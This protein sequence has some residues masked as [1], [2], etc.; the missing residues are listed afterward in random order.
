V[1][2]CRCELPSKE[3]ELRSSQA[4]SSVSEVERRG[5]V[6][7]DIDGFWRRPAPR[8][9]AANIYLQTFPKDSS[10]ASSI[11]KSSSR[12]KQ[13]NLTLIR[14][15]AKAPKRTILS[16]IT[17]Y[18]AIMPR[19]DILELVQAL[20]TSGARAAATFILND[21]QF[22]AIPQLAR[23]M[24][25]VPSGMNSGDSDVDLI[26]YRLSDASLFEEFQ[27]LPVPGGED[28]EFFSIGGRH[29]LA[30]ASLR[31]GKGP[32]NMVE[33]VSSAI[34][35]WQDGK[36]VEFQR[37]PTFAAKQWRYFAIEGRSFLA[38]A[39]GVT[40]P[41]ITARIPPESVIYEWDA[42][43]SSFVRFQTVPSGWG[44]NWLHFSLAGHDFLA[45][46]DQEM[47][48]VILRWENGKFEHFQALE[49]ALGRAFCFIETENESLLAFANIADDT[50]LYAW[51]GN[52]FQIRQRL[53]GPGGRE[54]ALVKHAEDSYLILVRFIT[55]SRQAPKTDLQ[56]AIYRLV[57]GFLEEALAFPTFGAT[58]CSIMTVK[59][60]TWLVVC[61]SLD[62]DQN[63]RVDTHIYRF[64]P[65]PATA[66]GDLPPKYTFQSSEFLE[67]FQVYTA[68][69]TSLGTQLA[70]SSSAKTSQY[71][72]LAATSSS[73][74][75]FPGCGGDPSYVS[76]RLTNRGFKEL[77]AISHFG[78]ALASLVQMYTVN[79]EDEAWRKHAQEL[80]DAAEK[81]KS[82]NSTELWR[83]RIRVEA[84][85]GREGAIAA[86]V[87]YACAITMKYLRLVISD[88]T[89]LTS[90]FLQ[91]EYLEARGSV[92]GATV[93]I[94]A[95]MIATFFLVGLDLAYQ[96]KVWLQDK[97]MDW[98]KTMVLV[99]GK[100]GRETAGVTVTSNAV[101][102]VIF[103]S[104][105]LM[106]PVERLYIAPHGP[107]IVVNNA[108]DM[109]LLRQYEKPM[110]MLWN[111]NFAMAQ[112]GPTMFG[113]YPRYTPEMRSRPIIAA[114]TTELS[115]MPAIHGPDDWMAMTTRMRIVLEDVRQLLSGC[116]TDYAAEQLRLH[117]NNPYAVVVPGLDHFNY[118][119]KP[120]VPIYPLNGG[121]NERSDDGKLLL[122]SS[123]FELEMEF[124]FPSQKCT[125]GDAEIAFREEGSG[126]QTIIWVHGLPLDS[127]SW[128]AQRLHF[129]KGYHNVYLDLRGYGES[130]KLPDEVQDV[131]QIYC[132]DI[133]TLMD[134]LFIQ[135]AHLVGFASAGHVALRFAAQNPARIQKL[136]TINGTPRFRRGEDWP[137]GFSE[138]AIESFTSAA[139]RD[140]IR[141]ITAAVLDPSVVFREL[142]SVD[143]QKVKAWFEKMSHNAGTKT[144]L[145]FFNHISRDDDRH[146]VPQILAPT[147]LITG[148]MSQEVPS[149]SAMYLRQNIKDARMVEIP[150]ADHFAFITRPVIV[151]ALIEGFLSN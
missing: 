146:L 134:H 62:K 36:F 99:I 116:V 13:L 117:G 102:Q 65:Q 3:S 33:N 145:G 17:H 86:M 91:E 98:T 57:D 18:A 76:F 59:D 143:A 60:E 4:V 82:A 103:Q 115:D 90:Q 34:W 84:F 58:D 151:N 139:A 42:S 95:V 118:P 8:R 66:R 150:D 124:D 19:P 75:L 71:P 89:K 15:E 142:S 120:R 130:S 51:D 6:G 74:L 147:L 107:N 69:D 104:S 136:V 149:Q 11:E 24:A 73:L 101:A 78:P 148:S 25:G 123:P 113:G 47:P 122:S 39:Q 138:E 9:S 20:P 41:G 55:G 80:L 32:Y 109:E 133:K 79:S 14:R 108:T 112:L 53:K 29:F 46:A 77:A 2:T 16:R 132:D 126:E 1:T 105:N 72:L 121:A 28:A 64:N 140:G 63:F 67:L 135:R 141:G 144:L 45:Y 23:D 106:L 81:A 87:D 56:S 119:Q 93:P 31:T 30:T 52:K 68:S 61:E 37:I 12:R 21:R 131:T 129:A 5:A 94:N 49:G 128:A 96:M 85:R 38:L 43:S 10:E 22:M 48:S 26:I 111:R 127:R 100:Q 50:L 35:E 40:L 92:L 125:F 27:R 97:N 88:P 44:Y 137:W 70:M 110:R 7:A 114:T 83:D 54:F